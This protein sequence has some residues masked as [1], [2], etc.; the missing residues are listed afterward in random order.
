MLNETKNMSIRL[1]ENCDISCLRLAIVAV[2]N[3]ELNLLTFVQCLVSV[4]LDSSRGTLMTRS[5]APLPEQFFEEP[6]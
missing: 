5:G 6:F 4:D 3:F 1:S 2:Y